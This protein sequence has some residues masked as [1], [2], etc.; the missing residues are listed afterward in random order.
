MKGELI[1]EQLTDALRRSCSCDIS[2]INIQNDA[3]G[4]GQLDHLITYRGRMLGTTDYS[5][6]GLVGLMQSWIETSQAFVTIDTFRMQ[7]DTTCTARLDTI[8][9]PDCLLV[10]G[11]GPNSITTNPT[12]NPDTTTT[13]DTGDSKTDTSNSKT[14]ASEP[15]VATLSAVRAGEVGGI[16]VGA[17]IILVLLVLMV[18]ILV[19]ALRKKTFAKHQSL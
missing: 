14:D 5:A 16:I 1:R 3:F 17:L 8:D 15:A 13:T 18:I 4:C 12:V 19:V 2:S 9:S 10:E 11:G 6:T 7:V